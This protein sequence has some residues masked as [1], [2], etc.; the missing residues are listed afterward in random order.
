MVTPRVLT[1][2][3]VTA[4]CSA[5]LL[6]GAGPAQAAPPSD[7]QGYTDSTA[8]CASASELVV[9]G[10]TAAS[11]VAICDTSAGL[12]YRGV[13]VRDG[14]RLITSAS[15]GSGGSY[16]AD[17]DGITYEV[18]ST[19]LTISTGSRTLRTETMLDFHSGT[20]GST[21][22]TPSTT[23]PSTEQPSTEAPVPEGPP[24]PAEVGGSGS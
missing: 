9:F 1:T 10:S 17:N 21:S 8:R 24:L 2:T 18:T 7:S 6:A 11:R 4:A 15:R 12:Q 5:A 3:L 13:R 19:A 22:T 20:A 14:A 23:T 16:V